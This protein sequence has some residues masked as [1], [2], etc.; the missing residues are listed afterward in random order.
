MN[1]HGNPEGQT[2]KKSGEMNIDFSPQKKEKLNDIGEYVDYEEV[3][4]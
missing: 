1:V 2:K 4:D 3:D